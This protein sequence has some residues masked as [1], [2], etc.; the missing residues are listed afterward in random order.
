MHKYKA[1]LQK[2]WPTVNKELTKSWD[3]ALVALCVTPACLYPTNTSVSIGIAMAIVIMGYAPSIKKIGK[4]KS[5]FQDYT[6][7]SIAF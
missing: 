5:A 4:L 6:T 3:H 7:Q 1:A 2:S